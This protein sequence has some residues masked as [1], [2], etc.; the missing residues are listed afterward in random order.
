M[1][2][3]IFYGSDNDIFVD[4]IQETDFLAAQNLFVLASGQRK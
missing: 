2:W 4:T 3:M 1:R